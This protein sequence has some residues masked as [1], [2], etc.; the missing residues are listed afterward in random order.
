[1]A[2]GGCACE[3]I[4]YT[5]PSPPTTLVNCHCV[6]CRKQAGAPYQ[7]W[8]FLP[9]TSIHWQT[10]PTVWK[11]SESSSRSFCPRC[12]SALTMVLAS[13]PS[14]IAMAAGTLDDECSSSVPPPTAHIFL[15]E[16]APWYELP[17]DGAQRWD[18]WGEY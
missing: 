5:S 2:S 6:Q 18:K 8:I 13:D 17:E 15:Q 9:T 3:Y 11:S 1:M 16:K 12:G 10:E 14:R 4:R 7:A